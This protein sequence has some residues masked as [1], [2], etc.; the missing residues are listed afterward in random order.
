M[1]VSSKIP[2]HIAGGNF[3]LALRVFFGYFLCAKESNPRA[4]AEALGFDL[5]F[6]MSD[7]T[8][9]HAGITHP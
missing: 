6:D 4:D 1:D 9:D 7:F 8:Q 3:G 5:V 2:D